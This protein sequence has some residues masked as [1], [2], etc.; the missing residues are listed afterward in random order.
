MENEPRIN[1]TMEDGT[2]V[3]GTRYNSSLWTFMGKAAL[4]NHVYVAA[5]DI[6]A[7]KGETLSEGVD[8]MLEHDKC[9]Y[10]AIG[11]VALTAAHLINLIPPK[12]DPFHKVLIWRG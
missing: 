1:F 3:E 10:V 2:T 11:G 4:Y 12:Y 5:N 8:R 9:K 6:L 7:P